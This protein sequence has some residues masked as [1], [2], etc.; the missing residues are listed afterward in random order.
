LGLSV[1]VFRRPLVVVRAQ[2]AYLEPTTSG[3]AWG[4]RPSRVWTPTRNRGSLAT[5]AVPRSMDF[6]VTAQAVLSLA[7]AKLASLC[8]RAQ[9]FVRFVAVNVHILEARLYHRWL[10]PMLQALSCYY[11]T[12]AAACIAAYNLLAL[13][14]TLCA[15]AVIQWVQH[16][17]TSQSSPAAELLQCLQNHSQ[18][19]EAKLALLQSSRAVD[20]QCHERM[21][22]VMSSSGLSA[23]AI[24]C[25]LEEGARRGVSGHDL[26][27]IAR[28]LSS[29]DVGAEAALR[30]AFAA[31][32][33][34]EPACSHGFRARD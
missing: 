1:Y 2:H 28:R 12:S 24:S 33:M 13:K 18:T 9:H 20:Q 26:E 27:R 3:R 30:Q 8:C 14:M 31:I 6:L 32:F 16:S 7:A 25:L 4:S 23:A 5:S 34:S 29:S 15:T 10:L 19:N 22:Q 11:M 21:A 17:G